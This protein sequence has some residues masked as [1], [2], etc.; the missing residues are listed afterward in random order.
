MRAFVLVLRTRF[1]TKERE[2][3]EKLFALFVLKSFGGMTCVVS[4]AR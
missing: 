2:K 4:G 3:K 1:V